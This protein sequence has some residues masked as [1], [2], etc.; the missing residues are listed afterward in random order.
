MRRLMVFY[1]K[2]NSPLATLIPS[3]AIQAANLAVRAKMLESGSCVINAAN[4]EDDA[5]KARYQ[6]SYQCFT[7]MEKAKYGERAAE[8]GLTVHL[9]FDTLQRLI[10]RNELYH[11]V[12]YLGG[13][14]AISKKW[15]KER[16]T[17]YR[18][19]GVPLGPV[20]L[21]KKKKKKEVKELPPKK[22]GR[23]L[24]VGNVLDAQVQLYLKE[25][26][27]NGAVINTAIVMATAEG[28]V[29]HHDLNLLAKRG[30]LLLLPNTGLDPLC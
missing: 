23:P 4:E 15:P 10:K 12:H 14:K 30:D 27:N 7:P 17:N 19:M 2:N 6:G 20:S 29:Q 1:Q 28:L 18:K 26:Q 8:Y 16:M 25:L 3:S 5:S 21:K 11:Q 24:L 13:E 9:R 22:R